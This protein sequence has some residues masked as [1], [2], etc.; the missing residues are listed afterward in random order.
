M[1]KNIFVAVDGSED[2]DKALLAAAEL[3]KTY[4]SSIHLVF[5]VQYQHYAMGLGSEV[6]FTLPQEELEEFA[7]DLLSTASETVGKAGCNKIETHQVL[8]EA[9]QAV[10]EIAKER[11][12]DLI[13]VG[14]K[15]HSDISGFL[16]GSVSHKICHLAH[17][18]CLVVR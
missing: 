8:G 2:S 13:V 11:E 17:C 4:D 16:L 3:A 1:F 9:G 15:G 12:A 6:A 14:S 18:A 10:T 5:A 7:K